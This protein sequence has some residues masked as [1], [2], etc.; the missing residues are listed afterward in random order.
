MNNQLQI[1]KEFSEFIGCSRILLCILVVY[2]HARML[3]DYPVAVDDWVT[4]YIK[5]ISF[6]L[7]ATAVPLFMMF[8]GYLLGFKFL[9]EGLS[10]CS[11]KMNLKKKTKSLLVPY[12]AWNILCF[13]LILVRHHLNSEVYIPTLW[14]VFYGISE[15]NSSLITPADGPLWFVRDLII[16]N[17]FSP[18]FYVVMHF[19]KQKG[20]LVLSIIYMLSHLLKGIPFLGV[21][22]PFMLGWSLVY[23]DTLF[24]KVKKPFLLYA[25][26]ILVFVISSSP[27]FGDDWFSYSSHLLNPLFGMLFACSLY[28]FIGRMHDSQKQKI[29]SLAMYSFFIFA[30]HGVYAR[31][32]TKTISFVLFKFNLDYNISLFIS[33]TITPFII[34]VLSIIMCKMLNKYS[35]PI[36][37]V[38][39]GGR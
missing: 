12:L 5:A 25:V 10:F 36:Y 3:S 17:L 20:L 19:M 15:N 39:S 4:C 24:L 11:Y 23:H 18:V 7:A 34:V 1:T 2:V 31:L 22:I 26:L 14:E 38:L 21:M 6:G 32:L 37:M 28:Q 35:H 8:S 16:F 13:L 9:R 33:Y 27:I 29:D 30:S